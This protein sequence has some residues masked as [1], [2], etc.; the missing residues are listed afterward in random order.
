MSN[1]CRIKIQKHY[2]RPWTYDFRQ[3]D[4]AKDL[5]SL[6]DKDI[7]EDVADRLLDKMKKNHKPAPHSLL[8]FVRMKQNKGKPMDAQAIVKMMAARMKLPR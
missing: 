1:L 8:Y 7:F 3:M 5:L 2:G 4:I 6:M